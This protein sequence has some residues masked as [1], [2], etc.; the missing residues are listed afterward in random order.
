VR[1]FRLDEGMPLERGRAVDAASLEVR[2]E[3]G[4]PPEEGSDA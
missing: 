1:G 2:G 4:S 3:G